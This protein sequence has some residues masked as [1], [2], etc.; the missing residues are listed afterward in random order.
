MTAILSVR[1][2]ARAHVH[3]G[4]W[5]RQRNEKIYTQAQTMTRNEIAEYWRLDPDT[6]KNILDAEMKRQN[7]RN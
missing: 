5:Y 3:P 1:G 4:P 2:Y 7:E 6:I